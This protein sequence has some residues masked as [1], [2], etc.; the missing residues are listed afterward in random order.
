MRYFY[1]T[2]VLLNFMLINLLLVLIKYL[3]NSYRIC[4]FNCDIRSCISKYLYSVHIHQSCR[5]I[6][7]ILITDQTYF[8]Y[9]VS[10]KH[11]INSQGSKEIGEDGRITFE[12]TPDEIVL[13]CRSA[14]KG[15]QGHYNITLK[16]P[17]GSDTAH[18]NLIILDK[19]GTPEGPL[20]VSKVT[21]DGCK[22]AWNPPKVRKWMLISCCMCWS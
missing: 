7:F 14:L 16:N 9:K 13:V 15:D 17:K 11:A 4:Y 20:E 22:L 5:W 19:P 21:A 12:K 6:T 8:Y 10:W 18:V 3:F 2:M 1:T